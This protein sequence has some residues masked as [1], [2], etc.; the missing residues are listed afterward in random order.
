M[1]LVAGLRAA[2]YGIPFQPVGG[3]H[4]SDLARVN[5]WQTVRDPYGSAVHGP[6]QDHQPAAIVPRGDE[7]DAKPHR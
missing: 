1:T 7:H 2:S 5:G 4:G 6:Q 3:V